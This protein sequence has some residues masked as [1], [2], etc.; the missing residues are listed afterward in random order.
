MHI[1]ENTDKEIVNNIREGLKRTGGYCPCR[2]K[3]LPEYKCM[4]QEFRD[5]IKDPDFEGFC[6][7]LL[8]YKHKD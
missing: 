6:H 4:C 1:T 2:L 5:Q 7:C 3:K 8:Y